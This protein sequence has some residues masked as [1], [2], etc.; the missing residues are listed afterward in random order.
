[1]EWDTAAADA[2]YRYSIKEGEKLSPLSYNKENFKNPY[3]LLGLNEN[4]NAEEL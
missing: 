2:V 3:F 1:M 4:I